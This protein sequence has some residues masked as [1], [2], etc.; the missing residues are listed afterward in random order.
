METNQE[1]STFTAPSS[2][3][4]MLFGELHG[5]YGNQF[6]DKFRSG[7]AVDGLDTGTENMKR[8][9][10]EKLRSRGMT[11]GDMKRGLAKCD[12]VKF[13]PSWS[14]FLELCK[15]SVDPLVAYYEAVAGVQ[16]RAKG[17][18]GIWS[19]PAIFWA[20]TPLSFDLGN[21]TYSQIKPRWDRALAEQ[22][23][24]GEWE[25]IPEPLLALPEPAPMSRE[26]AA[27]RLQEVGAASVT[28]EPSTPTDHKRWAR[29]AMED[30]KHGGKRYP[31]VTYKMA[32]EALEA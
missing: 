16:A 24:R 8:V 6:L 4:D 26:E 29:L 30:L 1:L 3:I 20:A 7:H 25:A 32:K 31:A 18:M 28:K 15:P 22:M 5:M 2:P 21:Q 11:V 23:E 13:P 9:W 27:Q 19:H 10:T 12:R 14:E 17:E